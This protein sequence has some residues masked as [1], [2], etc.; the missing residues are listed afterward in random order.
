MRL[1]TLSLL[2]GAAL[3]LS[4]LVERVQVTGESMRPA[5][6]PGDRLVVVRGLRP[7][8]GDIVTA[9][10]PRRPDRVVVKRVAEVNAAG[11]VILGDDPSTSTDSR[12]FGP[13][14]RARG[15]AVYRYAPAA[16]ATRLNRS[17]WGVRS[18]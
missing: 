3:A 5:L 15:R 9:A 2:A 4:R 1:S 8:V 6:F 13:V 11:V 16:A 12:H 7:R 10:D 18:T 14:P 17:R